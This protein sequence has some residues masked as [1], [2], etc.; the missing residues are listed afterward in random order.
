MNRTGYTSVAVVSKE[1]RI[2]GNDRTAVTSVAAVSR[3]DLIEVDRQEN[4]GELAIGG[5]LHERGTR[6]LPAAVTGCGDGG[7]AVDS[8]GASSA[9]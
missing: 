9:A 3:R 5:R 7:P 6:I 8:S 4:G 2:S 1:S